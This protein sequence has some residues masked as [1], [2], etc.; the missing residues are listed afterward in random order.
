MIEPW[1]KY[2]RN[3]DALVEESIRVA[4][5]ASLENALEVFHGDGLTGPNPLLNASADLKD[6]KIDFTPSIYDIA[7]TVANIRPELLKC[8]KHIP[9]LSDKFKVFGSRPEQ[10]YLV[11]E[12]DKDCYALQEALNKGNDYY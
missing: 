8:V 5:K 12:K 11:M 6:N 9:R 3:F 2:V 10:F 4:M 1:D 7:K